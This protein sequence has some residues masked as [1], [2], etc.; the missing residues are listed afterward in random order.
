[1]KRSIL[2]IG[3][4]LAI[5]FITLGQNVAS[6]LDKAASAYGA[7]EMLE[8]RDN[9]KTALVDINNLL[10][11]KIL[12]QYPASINGLT[13]SKE[14]DLVAG[15][16][17]FAE[18]MVERDYGSGDK[19]AKLTLSNDSPMIT[20]VNAFLGNSMLTSLV[21]AQTGQQQITVAGYKG[22]LEETEA[23]DG[24]NSVTINIPLGDS[25]F[26]LETTG[27]S[28]DEALAAANTCN[29]SDIAK[30]IK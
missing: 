3:L 21:G 13:Y 15:G 19:K 1:M 26:T 9:L 25:L 18:L 29:L 17:G 22:M 14:N 28:T 10:G 4:L 24:P 12:E 23:D 30:L 5:P 11:A 2:S 16:V 20:A 7:N 8:A 6:S 27:F